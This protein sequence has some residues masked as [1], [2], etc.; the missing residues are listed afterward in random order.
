MY[1]SRF[2]ADDAASHGCLRCRDTDQPFPLDLRMAFQPI[3][4]V[5]R[6]EVFAYEALVRGPQGEGAGW[7]LGQVQAEQLYR[8]DQTCRVLAIATAAELGMQARLSINFAPNAVYEPASCIRLTLAA[9]ERVGFPI[10]RL[11]FELTEG[12]RISD[13]AHA[14]GVLEYYARRGFTTAID[15]FGAGF[16]GLAL[17]ARFQPHVLKLDME[18][19]RDIDTQPAKQAIVEGVVTM[20]TRLGS[21]MLAEGVETR[22]EL[23]W[24][25]SIGVELFQGYLFA[26][27]RLG[28]L[29][30]PDW[31]VLERGGGSTP[32][33][34]VRPQAGV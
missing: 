24:L 28:A 20:A 32:P 31:S 27:P 26:R 29:P 4:D 13:P 7:V 22:A 8:F 1:L 15:D 6:R 3:V 19:V 21:R 14:L 34:H 10:D 11:M 5:E 9:S 12:E 23:D 17:L 2:F 16:S 30:E 25:R 33:P 18:L